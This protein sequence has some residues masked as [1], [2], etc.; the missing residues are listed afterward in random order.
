MRIQREWSF[1]LTRV[2]ESPEELLKNLDAQASPLEITIQISLG[3][4]GGTGLFLSVSFFSFSSSRVILIAEVKN[5]WAWPLTMQVVRNFPVLICSASSLFLILIYT[6]LS[7]LEMHIS[8]SVCEYAFICNLI[9]NDPYYVHLNIFSFSFGLYVEVY[10]CKEQLDP[11]IICS[12]P[13]QH[14]RI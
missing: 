1:S 13:C 12:K 14:K 11:L 5:W 2:L 6:S 7:S 8:S 4:G 3:W 10:F 9:G